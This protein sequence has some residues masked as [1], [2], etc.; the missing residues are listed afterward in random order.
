MKYR[1]FMDFVFFL[2]F[3]LKIKT[4][5]KTELMELTNCISPTVF[6]SRIEYQRFKLT[7]ITSTKIWAKQN[8]LG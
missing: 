7:K 2:V 5:S 1:C 3:K 6:L 8:S 4:Y